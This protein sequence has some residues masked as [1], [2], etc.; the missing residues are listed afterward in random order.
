[1]TSRRD[2]IKAG[3]MAAIAGTVPSSVTLGDPVPEQHKRAAGTFW[4]DG[5]RMV[6]SVSMQMEGGAQPTSGAESPMPKID[7]KYPDLPASKWYDY[8]YKE[9]LPRLLEV[10]DRRKIKVTSHMVGAAV[11]LHPALAKEIVQRGD[12]ATGHGSIGCRISVR[13][14]PPAGWWRE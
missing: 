1:M 9:G 2:L 10:F 3:V 13:R 12:E 14:G 11:D 7:P 6:I 8:G 5:A 4:P